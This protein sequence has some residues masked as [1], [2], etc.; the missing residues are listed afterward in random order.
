MIDIVTVGAG[1]GSVAWLSPEGALKVGPRSAGADPGPL[2]Y[3]RGGTEPTVTDAHLVLGRIPPHLLGGEVP[4][5][6]AAAAA[7]LDDARRQARH[8]PGVGGRRRAGDLGLEPGQR[9]APDHRPAWTRRPRL[10]PGHLRRVGLAAAVPAA[11]HRRRAG[12]RRPP[13]PGQPVGVRAADRRRQ[14][15][16]GPDAR[17]PA[18]PTSTRP[19]SPPPSPPSRNGPPRALDA[20]GFA[21]GRAP[22][23]ALGRPALLRPGLRGP[24]P[25]SRR[26]R[27]RRPGRGRRRPRSTTPTS[28]STATASATTATQ[29]VEWVN[30]RV[31][32]IGP[33]RRPTAR[34]PPAP[35]ATAGAER[36][37]GPLCFDPSSGFVD[38]AIYRRADLG[39]GGPW[40][41]GR[42]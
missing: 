2:C 12:R 21:A 15:R 16:P 8:G 4:L 32:G 17:S 11:G 35:G 24:G 22:L 34:A 18:T 1:G 20:E 14:E 31:T 6:P 13:R 25:G 26:R 19:P 33:I 36:A 30:L 27:R 39:A 7:G 5:D 23:P 41:R 10:R 9:P 38:T 37:P 40:S 29:Q 3:G 28:A 42:R